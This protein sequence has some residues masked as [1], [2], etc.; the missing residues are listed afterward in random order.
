MAPYAKSQGGPLDEDDIDL[1]LQWFHESSGVEKPIEMSTK[2]INGKCSA[3][4][5]TVCQKLCSPVMV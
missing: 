2:P 3:R 1:L 5:S 4:K